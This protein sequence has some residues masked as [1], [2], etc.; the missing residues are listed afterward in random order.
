MTSYRNLCAYMETRAKEFDLWLIDHR[1]LDLDVKQAAW[2]SLCAELRP[3]ALDVL[4][5]D[6][7]AE[8]T[9]KELEAW[10]R[11]HT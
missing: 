10:Q 5:Y 6:Q 4:A 3:I 11:W 9:A 1:Y 7:Q 8:E 2:N